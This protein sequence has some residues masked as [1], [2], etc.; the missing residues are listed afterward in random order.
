MSTQIKIPLMDKDHAD[1]KEYNLGF[2]D[3]YLQ[4]IDTLNS[5]ITMKSEYD[6]SF[7][8]IRHAG[9]TKKESYKLSTALQHLTMKHEKE[10][11]LLEKKIQSL[12]PREHIGVGKVIKC[13]AGESLP[14]CIERIQQEKANE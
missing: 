4:M 7:C 1:N 13:L 3:C 10:I 14:A 8:I 12:E 5:L 6:K 2:R 11:L 9:I